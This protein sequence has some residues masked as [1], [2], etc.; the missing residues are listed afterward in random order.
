LRSLLISILLFLPQTAFA[1]GVDFREVSSHPS[2]A[3]YVSV[4]TFIALGCWI[5]GIGYILV[6][7]FHYLKIKRDMQVASGER[8]PKAGWIS[9]L[10]SGAGLLLFPFAMEF[11]G[12]CIH[13]V[14]M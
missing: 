6:A 9:F 14:K 12:K 7:A 13:K 1:G 11:V 4:L 8:P 5:V 2:V 10:M 3:P